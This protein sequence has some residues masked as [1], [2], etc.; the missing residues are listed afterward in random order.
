M[1]EQVALFK[2][3]M[4]LGL[5]S[6]PRGLSLMKHSERLGKWIGLILFLGLLAGCRRDYEEPITDPNLIIGAWKG[7]GTCSNSYTGG[8][9]RLCPQFVLS[10]DEIAIYYPGSL[11]TYGCQI[12][13]NKLVVAGSPG[14][15]NFEYSPPGVIFGYQYG[16]VLR[17]ESTPPNC[18][19]DGPY[20]KTNQQFPDFFKL[21]PRHVNNIESEAILES[22][23]AGNLRVV[24][25]I[26]DQLSDVQLEGPAAVEVIVLDDP[27]VTA[28]LVRTGTP[29]N[30]SGTITVNFLNNYCNHDVLGLV[31]IGGMEV[32]YS[33]KKYM[34]GWAISIS[35]TDMILTS[36]AK[37]QID[38]EINLSY[39]E[40][41][42]E[43]VVGFNISTNGKFNFT[44][45]GSSKST[46]YSWTRTMGFE[47]HQETDPALDTWVFLAGG[48][49][50]GMDRDQQPYN[51][52]ILENIQFRRPC[53]DRDP[54]IAGKISIQSGAKTFSASY[55]TG[56]VYCSLI[57]EIEI[58]GTTGQWYVRGDGDYSN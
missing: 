26:L 52:S 40:N 18:N 13:N 38:G 55:S 28:S 6:L 54:P 12:I 25:E 34:P 29:V 46:N 2:F 15:I 31:K 27:C 16:A 56:G 51:I 36:I 10:S 17:I 5:H 30:P 37:V 35:P 32:S 47:W 19:I 3:N 53:S 43:N 21:T 49:G 24:L 48:S 41:A 1:S 39:V 11:E 14:T 4:V 22:Y 50:T 20:H 57:A 33:G 8:C 44:L 7:S 58:D 9:E 42:T 45:G 23:L